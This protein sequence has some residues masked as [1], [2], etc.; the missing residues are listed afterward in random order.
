MQYEILD[1]NTLRVTH[2]K[3]SINWTIRGFNNT[4][5]AKG[6]G[7]LEY[8]NAYLS[9]LPAKHI[10]AMFNAMVDVH[11]A[12][13]GF[14]Q[15]ETRRRRIK[16]AV[17]EFIA[18]IDQDLLEH[19]VTNESNTPIPTNLKTKYTDQDKDPNKTFLRS[20]YYD[21]IALTIV[22][23]LMSGIWGEFLYHMHA[24][25]GTNYKEYSAYRLLDGTW[26]DSSEAVLRLLRYIMAWVNQQK[27]SNSAIMGGVSSEELP[28]LIMSHILVRKMGPGKIDDNLSSGGI[29]AIIYRGLNSFLKDLAGKFS[30]LTDKYKY[31]KSDSKD[32]KNNH[33]KLE[34]YMITQVHSLGDIAIRRQFANRTH[35]L[36]HRIDPTLPLDLLDECIENI[37]NIYGYK[38]EQH[39]LMLTQ[40]ITYREVPS[41]I[42]YNLTR[43]EV[44][45]LIALS[46]ALM[47]HWGF[48]DL[49]LLL[50]ATVDRSHIVNAHYVTQVNRRIKPDMMVELSKLY[51]HQKPNKSK[52]KDANLV[53]Q[54]ISKYKENLGRVWLHF[55]P[56][57]CMSDYA[58]STI[59][60]GKGSLVPDDL[61]LQIIEMLIRVGN[62]TT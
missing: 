57:S 25:L 6:Q 56:P 54:A 49:A 60:D 27:K 42:Y 34:L 48:Q 50:T 47:W 2:G 28:T 36:A 59:V 45:N 11:E 51:P 3:Q 19:W 44:F 23:K 62:P 20:E 18:T 58:M 22:L 53:Q 4:H 35:Q 16:T 21:L 14:G 1:N 38:I 31:L 26:V 8:V 43:K 12:F 15:F 29:I 5:L 40:W 33:S 17:E 32:E 61:S 37:Q 55:H 7:G 39:I 13:N 10:E 46:Q 52:P 41:R 30:A 24:K 9:W